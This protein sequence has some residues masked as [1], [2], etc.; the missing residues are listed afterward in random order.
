M[1]IFSSGS[2]VQARSACAATDVAIELRIKMDATGI[3]SLR[4]CDMMVTS[5]ADILYRKKGPDGLYPFFPKISLANSRGVSQYRS[6]NFS[7]GFS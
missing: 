2:G 1:A 5:R 4:N 3:N 6:S 7:G